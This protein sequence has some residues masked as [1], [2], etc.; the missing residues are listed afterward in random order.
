MLFRNFFIKASQEMVQHQAVNRASTGLDTLDEILHGGLPT[1][2]L[3][4]INGAP[5][6]GKSTLALHFLTAAA[7][8]EKVMCLALSQR[9]ESL[10]QT[11]ASVGID[12]SGISFCDLSSV[13]AIKA[14][15]QNQTIFDTSEVELIET[16][17]AIVETIDAAKPSRVVFDGISQ[18]R[19][20]SG[21]EMIYR[22]QLFMLRDYMSSREI[23]VLLTDS[24]EAASGDHELVSMAHGVITLSL[25][26]TAH[27]SDH[28]YLRVTKI[29]ASNYEP[30]VHDFEITDSGLQV[31]RSH[32]QAENIKFASAESLQL[33]KAEKR[34]SG[35]SGLDDLIGGG[36]LSGT[37][38]LLMGP[39]GTGKTS[40]ATLFLYHFAQQ[41]GRASI[42]LFDES[43]DTFARRSKGLGM[44]LVP[45]VEQDRLRLHELSFGNI[46]PGKFSTLVDR[47]VEDW[48]A[49]MV[50][51]D[52]L[53]GYMNAM[54][55]RDRLIARMHELMKRL[56]EQGVLTFLMVAQHG[57]VGISMDMTVDISYLA[58]TVLL[59]RH[60]EA[61]GEIRQAISVY[62]NRYG[63]HQ[64]HICEVKIEEGGIE[65]GRTLGGFSGILSGMP[66]RINS[67]QDYTA[68]D[69]V[70]NDGKE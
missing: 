40:I 22:Q 3:Y 44:D 39:S 12:V 70:M 62:K 65:I 38:C 59:M 19:M 48:G 10:K 30:G 17:K 50:V 60:F 54:P 67:N 11:A 32:R 20:L 21:N 63:M 18:L 58:D 52:T 37:T 8:G 41:G 29:R 33:A 47:D 55:G 14:L 28:R 15:S 25:S 56:N 27:G 53:T 36:L 16:M 43:I 35:L 31:Y 6:S 5:G 9:I 24:P 26:T 1:G 49:E 7:A 61:A 57:V 2:E 51:V 4:V 45:L 34:I 42:F 69:F 13:A 23:T 68:N 64:R 66:Q 46:T